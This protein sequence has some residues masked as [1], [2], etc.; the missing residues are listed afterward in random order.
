MTWQRWR[1]A[2]DDI[3]LSIIFCKKRMNSVL[4]TRSCCRMCTFYSC[5]TDIISQWNILM[6]CCSVIINFTAL[7]MF[8]HCNIPHT[9]NHLIPHSIG[10]LAVA[11][12]KSGAELM[13]LQTLWGCWWAGWC[14]NLQ[15]FRWSVWV[16]NLSGSTSFQLFQN[17][18]SVINDV[19]NAVL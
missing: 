16:V 9:V 12:G 18:K 10:A 6:V 2:F 3:V 13:K 19:N 11:R 1:E 17:I 14:R 15:L 8:P 7:N 4:A 5:Y